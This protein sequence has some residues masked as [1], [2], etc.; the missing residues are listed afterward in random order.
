MSKEKVHVAKG[1]F[2]FRCSDGQDMTLSFVMPYE[3]ASKIAID[4]ISWK[5]DWVATTTTVENYQENM[6]NFLTKLNK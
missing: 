5:D 1:E 2:I 3:I 6:N 4:I